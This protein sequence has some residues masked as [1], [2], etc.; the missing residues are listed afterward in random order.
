GQHL[1]CYGEES[2]DSPNLDRF[3]ES[4]VLFENA[5]CSSPCC[6]PSRGC[7][8]SGMHA[9]TNGLMGLVNRG[10]S[11]PESTPTIVDYF[12]EGGYETAHFGFQ[13][14]RYVASANRYQV[15][16]APDYPE[17][18]WV[19][20]Q[21]DWVE[22]AI[23]G[24]IGYL[25]SRV[26]AERPFYL[27]VGTV[28]VHASRWQGMFP[29]GHPQ[30]RSDTYGV[31]APEDV[32]VPPWLPDTRA[33]RERL[34]KFQGAIRYLDGHVQ[35]LLDAIDR[36]GYAE[37]TLVI[38]TTDHG[39]AEQRAK[40]WLYDRGVEIALL[41][42]L[43]GRVQR[44]EGALRPGI[45]ISHLIQNIDIAPTLL[46]AAG[47][48]IPEVLQGRSFWSLLTGERYTPH[49]AIVIERNHHGDYD[50]MRAVRTPRYHYI[51]NFAPPPRKTW[52]QSTTYLYSDF[53]PWYGQF[54]P[55]PGAP[56]PEEELFDVVGDPYE[57]VN[58]ADDPEYAA[59]RRE[60]AAYLSDWQVETDDLLL[61]G[62]I[63]DKLN[64]WPEEEV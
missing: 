51:R 50:P 9:H 33:Q 39:I 61:Y 5:F 59:V 1:N 60:L 58:L 25:E 7:A 12:N 49:D 15:E 47:L 43:P 28:E 32:D 38:F 18:D 40:V 62:P 13:H 46:D 29:E 44:R 36:L 53:E 37:D 4:G 3:A 31:A 8:M 41:V 17:E 45:R 2:V 48:P 52:L 20:R 10:W 34:G 63:P 64:P 11:M 19:N 6:S 57:Y 21:E 24:A 42:R 23:D 26:G 55:L 14:E 27:N 56:R 16:G 35:R 30:N 22:P 54:D